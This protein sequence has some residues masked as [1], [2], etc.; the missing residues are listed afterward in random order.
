MKFNFQQKLVI[1]TLIPWS[2][3]LALANSRGPR[4]SDLAFE[5][6]VYTESNDKRTHPSVNNYI[7]ATKVER[8][9]SESSGGDGGSKWHREKRSGRYWYS[10]RYKRKF[11]PSPLIWGR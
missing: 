3:L 1:V 6:R 4:R 9:P 7:N 2:A 11:R 10:G 5:R 8:D